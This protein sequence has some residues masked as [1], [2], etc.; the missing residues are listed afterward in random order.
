MFRI[1][2]V[3]I[4]SSF[5]VSLHCQLLICFFALPFIHVSISKC[6]RY[7][8]RAKDACIGDNMRYEADSHQTVWCVRNVWKFSYIIIGHRYGEMKKIQKH[9]LSKIDK[10]YKWLTSAGIILC[11]LNVKHV[12][13]MVIRNK[14]I[15]SNHYYSAEWNPFLEW[16][17]KKGFLPRLFTKHLS[18]LLWN[19]FCFHEHLNGTIQITWIKMMKNSG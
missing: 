15:H 14:M 7:N 5:S 3:T 9:S 16:I 6:F 8:W 19:I 12:G 1:F 13:I 11:V 18:H 4:R 2:W 17:P 10:W